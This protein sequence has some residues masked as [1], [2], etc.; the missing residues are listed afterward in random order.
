MRKRMTGRNGWIVF[1]GTMIAIDVT[2]DEENMLS[3]SFLR[4]L[5]RHPIIAHYF[6]LSCAA[7]LLRWV[8]P[9]YDVWAYSAGVAR[10][11]V[12][13]RRRTHDVVDYLA[14]EV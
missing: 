4:F 13:V 2:F 11:T 12:R 14:V 10:T 7:H 1:L 9:R 5:R 8:P 3:Q 6:V